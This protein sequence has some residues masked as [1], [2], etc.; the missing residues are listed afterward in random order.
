MTYAELITKLR[1]YTEVSSSV[2]TSTILDGIIRDV[3]FKIFR[4]V[5]ADYSRKYETSLS[6]GTNRYLLLPTDCYII[7]S[8]QLTS[9]TGDSSFERSMLEKKD[10]SFIS[11]FYPSTT[12]SGTP[13]YYANWDPN[14]IVMAPTPDVVYGVQLNYI[15][16]PEAL[17]SSNTTT[18][19]STKDPDLLLYGCLVNCYGYLKGPMDMYKLYEAKYNEAI[20]TYALQQMGRR[21]RDDYDFGV[22]RIKI[23]SPSP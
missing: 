6:T 20:Q 21:R 1:D 10:T 2:L 11:E 14:N 9:K 3:E 17:S 23:P 7:R 15:F 8:L 4:E 22:P 5:D 16:T 12:T 18:T 19:L 13:K